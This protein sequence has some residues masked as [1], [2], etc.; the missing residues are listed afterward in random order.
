[1]YKVNSTEPTIPEINKHTPN[2]AIWGSSK[3]YGL[4]SMFDVEPKLRNVPYRSIDAAKNFHKFLSPFI[5]FNV[6]DICVFAYYAPAD[7]SFFGRPFIKNIIK[8]A[9]ATAAKK[10]LE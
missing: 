5:I 9:F 7:G 6:Y 10:Y 3:P 4:N 1:M 8:N 2:R